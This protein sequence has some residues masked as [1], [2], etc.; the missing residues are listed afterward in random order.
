MGG[1]DYGELYMPTKRLTLV[2]ETVDYAIKKGL[3]S[4]GLTRDEALIHV[5]QRET[6]SIF[7]YKEAVVSITYDE[8]DSLRSLNKRRIEEFRNKFKFRF[9]DGCAEVQVPAAFYD[10]SYVASRQEREEYLREFLTENGIEEPDDDCIQRI[11]DDYNQQYAYAK[12]VELACLPLNRGG[13]RIFIKIDEDKM[14]VQAILFPKGKVDRSD[15]FRVLKAKGIIKGVLANN[16]NS[17]LESGYVGY[18]DIARGKEAIDDKPGEVEKFFAEDEHTEFSKMMTHLSIDMRNVKDLNIADRNQLLI[19]IGD[20]EV[21]QDGYTVAGEVL[22][23][24]DLVPGEFGVKAGEGV[25]ISDDGK[26]IFAKRSGHIKWNAEDESIDIEPLYVVDGNVDFSE[27]NIVGF[28]GKILI[29]GD[30]KPKFTVIADGDV[31]IHGSVE[32]AVI[33]SNNGSVLIAGSVIHNSEGMIQAKQ[34]AHVN[35]ATN[36]CI[37]ANRIIVEK[38][39]INSELEADDIIEVLGTPGVA[40]GGKIYA[41]SLIKVNT[42]GSESGVTTDIRSGD[43][44]ELK[45]K[46]RTLTQKMSKNAS[47]LREAQQIVA[48]LEKREAAQE[49][50]SSQRKQLLRAREEIPELEESLSYGEEREVKMKT[51]IAERESARVEV[52][53]KLHALVDLRIF[54]AYTVPETS[55]VNSGFKCQ[56]GEIVRYPL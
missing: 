8:S 6:Q 30:V 37:R 11:I 23:K 49:L 10:D 14:R 53:K 9:H 35:I 46:L 13:G 44:T 12:V 54:E 24:Q 45:K 26:Q 2:E 28:V 47:K 21:G 20:M 5:L 32:D 34:T 19:R 15:V 27:G 38:E 42:V 40:I 16:I 18:F 22:K 33:K 17:V 29:K 55:E 43:V 7:G 50:T 48:I 52:L 36:A 3:E 4:L 56:N 25:Y 31:E 51:E 41:K 39:V 1:L